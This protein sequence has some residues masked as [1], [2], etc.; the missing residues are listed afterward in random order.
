MWSSCLS[1]ISLQYIEGFFSAAQWSTRT[2]RCL[3]EPYIII[4]IISTRCPAIQAQLFQGSPRLP[5][6]PFHAIPRIY[7]PCDTC[8]DFYARCWKTLVQKA[9]LLN[10]REQT[11]SQSTSFVISNFGATSQQKRCNCFQPNS[12]N[13]HFFVDMVPMWW[14]RMVQFCGSRHG[15]HHQGCLLREPSLCSSICWR[16]SHLGSTLAIAA[17]WRPVAISTGLPSRLPFSAAVCSLLPSRASL[18]YG[19][20]R[21]AVFR[22]IWKPALDL[23]FR[24]HTTSFW[25]SLAAEV[26]S[27][28]LK[29]AELTE[30]QESQRLGLVLDSLRSLRRTTW[31]FACS[32]RTPLEWGFIM[33]CCGSWTTSSRA[34]FP[35]WQRHDLECLKWTWRQSV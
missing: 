32:L 12:R 28:R 14:L 24:S 33:L 3:A 7:L 2:L 6:S 11:A 25:M 26:E 8:F 30:E 34:K 16:L 29:V 13:L 17:L 27:L 9:A 10:G 1:C 5:L 35:T 23:P 20:L 22:A 4:L 18:P 15:P 19:A 31:C 21:W